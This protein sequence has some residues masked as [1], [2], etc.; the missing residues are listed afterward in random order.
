MTKREFQEPM[1]EVVK[2]EVEDIVTMSWGGGMMPLGE[3]GEEET[4]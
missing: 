1:C 2:L 4:W 3:E